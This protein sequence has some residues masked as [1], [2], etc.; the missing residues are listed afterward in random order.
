MCNWPEP[1]VAVVAG[2]KLYE[3]GHTHQC[4]HLHFKAHVCMQPSSAKDVC[5]VCMSS[6]VCTDTGWC[7]IGSY[8]NVFSFHLWPQQSQ[9]TLKTVQR[10]AV[11]IEP[12]QPGWCWPLLMP[13]LDK[14]W[15]CKEAGSSEEK[16]Y[17]AYWPPNE[18]AEQFLCCGRKMF[19]RAAASPKLS[20]VRTAA[21]S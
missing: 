16:C 10:L 11:M 13:K 3:E 14:M 19:I 20:R 1:P 7:K 8:K 5:I 15:H 9:L 12:Q 21:R 4:G 18:K 6:V 2:D 17:F